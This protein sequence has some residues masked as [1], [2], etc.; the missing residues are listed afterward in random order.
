MKTTTK[1]ERM[2]AYN[3]QQ[4]YERYVNQMNGLVAKLNAFKNLYETTLKDASVELTLIDL[5]GGWSI[6]SG[7]VFTFIESQPQ[8][9]KQPLK[10]FY[11]KEL[12][13]LHE[14]FQNIHIARMSDVPSSLQ[15]P[16]NNIEFD[17]S[18][19]VAPVDRELFNR[20]IDSDTYEAFKVFIDA[21]NVLFDMYGDAITHITESLYPIEQA[22]IARRVSRRM[23]INQLSELS[24]KINL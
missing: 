8:G 2:I 18:F 24:K 14:E 10:A 20:Y 11:S 23:S 17:G 9:L 22:G 12:Q 13:I 3:G 1:A 6:I 7:K 21:Q 5:K 4:E 15:Y 16:L 19:K